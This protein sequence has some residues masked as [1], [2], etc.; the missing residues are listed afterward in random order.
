M[1]EQEKPFASFEAV[2]FLAGIAAGLMGVNQSALGEDSDQAIL[3]GFINFLIGISLACF[4]GIIVSRIITK[5][6][7][8]ESD[9]PFIKLVE[10]MLLSSGLSC[11]MC[12]T[13]FVCF[14]I[15]PNS[16]AL[17]IAGG[18]LIV[19]IAVLAHL[20]KRLNQEMQKKNAKLAQLNNNAMHSST[21]EKHAEDLA[22]P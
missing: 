17:V 3:G 13:A 12:A 16:G 1:S 8:A 15:E 5:V 9:P 11:L 22:S 4:G 2:T 7:I 14:L 20:K 10:M 19:A 18:M 21:S 6:E